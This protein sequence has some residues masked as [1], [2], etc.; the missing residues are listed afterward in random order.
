MRINRIQAMVLGFT[1]VAWGALLVIL[2]ADPAL[3]DAN[4]TQV[5]LAPGPVVRVLFFAA[6]SVFLMALGIGTVRRWRWM[7]WLVL[8]A[9]A[10]GAIRV[11]VSALQLA[12]VLPLDVPAWYAALQAGIGVVQVLIAIAMFRGYR[13]GG[14]W[15]A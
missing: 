15:G 6:L 13:R 2:V 5:G 3:Y 10:A 4:F 9:F 11:P 14:V 7:F 12:G 8:I 1:S